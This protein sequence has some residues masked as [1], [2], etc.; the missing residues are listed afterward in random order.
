MRCELPRTVSF[1]SFSEKWNK[2]VGRKL[3]SW[4]VE[5]KNAFWSQRDLQVFIYSVHGHE[6][7]LEHHTSLS[8]WCIWIVNECRF[9]FLKSKKL[10]VKEEKWYSAAVEVSAVSSLFI[11]PWFVLFNLGSVTCLTVCMESQEHRVGGERKKKKHKKGMQMPTICKERG[12]GVPFPR[13]LW[14]VLLRKKTR[15]V[16]E[17]L[18]CCLTASIQLPGDWMFKECGFC[19][20]SFQVTARTLLQG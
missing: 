6:G 20:L 4:D 3:E 2:K 16:N 15:R 9:F 8:D 10:S 13:R 5:Q 11:P 7:P 12:G 17:Q 18:S 1:P 19:S 14:V